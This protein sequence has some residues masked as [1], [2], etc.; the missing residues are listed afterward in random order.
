MRNLF[1]ESSR[2]CTSQNTTEEKKS[3][4]TCGVS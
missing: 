2:A 3:A 4:G 1:D